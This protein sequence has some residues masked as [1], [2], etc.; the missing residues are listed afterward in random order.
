MSTPAYRRL[1]LSRICFEQHRRVH[2]QMRA[3]GHESQ[4]IVIADDENLEIAREMGFLTIE[5][6]NYE[7][8]RK[9]NDGYEYAWMEGYDFTL[10]FGSDSWIDPELFRIL[11]ETGQRLS[12]RLIASVNYGV[13][14]RHGKRWTNITLDWGVGNLIPTWVLA[15]LSGRPCDEEARR[16][17]DTSTRKNIQAATG[18]KVRTIALHPNDLIGFQSDIQVTPYPRYLRVANMKERIGDTASLLDP[19]KKHYD[20]DL[21]ERIVELYGAA[22]DTAEEAAE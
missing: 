9:F 13:L 7:L 1:E 17:C 4:T 12:N 22:I 14:H 19:L 16:Y 8:G 20:A 15:A 11:V 18:A 2:E 5:R 6:P 10:P 3:W 21:I